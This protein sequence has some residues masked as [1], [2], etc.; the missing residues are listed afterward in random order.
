MIGKK[1][2]EE[3]FWSK[4]DKTDYC[5]NWNADTIHNGYGRIRVAG[6]KKLAHRVSYEL[7]FGPISKGEGYHGTCVLHKCDN[8]RCVNPEHL[9]P[10]TQRENLLRGETTMPARN[11]LKTHCP[12]GHPY[13]PDN[14]LPNR[15][16]Q[17]DRVCRTC[18]IENC[19]RYYRLH[20]KQWLPRK[21]D[22]L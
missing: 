6:K 10:V 14:L 5:W 7:A 17:G 8:R 16:K 22:N 20:P 3:R 12:R 9:E 11:V 4:V 1:S 15:L 19:R 2:L 13:T 18:N 21:G